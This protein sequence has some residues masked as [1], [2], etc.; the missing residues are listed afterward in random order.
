MTPAVTP[1]ERVRAAFAEAGVEGRLHA[2]GLHRSRPREVAVDADEPVVMASVYKLVLLVAFARLVDDGG[3]DPTEPVTVPAAR[4]TPGPTGLSAL[5]DA[6]T[7][8]WRD[9]M[10]LTI[11]HSDN[12]AAD[13]VLARVGLDR[14]DA[15]LDGFGLHATR[16]LSGTDDVQHEL[17]VQTGARDVAAAFAALARDDGVGD[18]AAYDPALTSATTARDTTR[19]L[20]MIWDDT[21]AS[22]EGCRFARDLLGAQIWTH[23]LRAGFPRG[24]RVAGKTGTIGA[25]RNEVGVVT[26]DG[27][28]PV[29]VAVFTRAARADPVL[30]RADAVIGEAARIAVTDLRS[31]RVE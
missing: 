20:G 13:V 12:T 14:L 1:A 17:R 15:M 26:F 30:P 18:V 24:A 27:E 23:R 7:A 28:H 16:V 8:T 25:V 31:G 4:R 11:T 29:A 9:L 22:P 6:V 5:R 3:L 2:V 19:L 21:A 10:T